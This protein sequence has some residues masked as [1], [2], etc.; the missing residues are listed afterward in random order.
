MKKSPHR[1][2]SSAQSRRSPGT[3]HTSGFSFFKMFLHNDRKNL[4]KFCRA[5]RSQSWCV[6]NNV[7]AASY[8]HSRRHVPH[9]SCKSISEY[10]HCRMKVI[11]SSSFSS[12]FFC[13]ADHV[14]KW[15][16]L[17][18]QIHWKCASGKQHSFLFS[19]LSRSVLNVKIL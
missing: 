9:N 19:G 18:F 8:I 3:A 17:L 13:F 16:V 11:F 5:W 4:Q 2:K 1:L 14:R 7:W 10:Q 6:Q 12:F 15:K